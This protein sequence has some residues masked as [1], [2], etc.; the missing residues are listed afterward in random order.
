MYLVHLQTYCNGDKQV[1]LFGQFNSWDRQNLP[2]KD[3]NGDGIFEVEIPLDPGRYEYKFYV[4]G[5]ELVDPANP[6][7]S[8][9]RYGRF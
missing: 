2:M 7:K 3:S 8:V 5:K 4:D 9:K 6:D 1:S